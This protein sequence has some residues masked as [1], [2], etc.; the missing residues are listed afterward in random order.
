MQLEVITLSKIRQT[1]EDEYYE[2][3]LLHTESKFKALHICIYM[4]AHTHSKDVC[5]YMCMAVSHGIRDHERQ[6]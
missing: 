4:H 1:Q 2:C 3:F 6:R 5:A